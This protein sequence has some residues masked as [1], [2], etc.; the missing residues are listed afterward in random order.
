[1]TAEPTPEFEELAADLGQR[2][3][4]A[5][6]R[7]LVLRFGDETRIVGVA[8]RMPPAATLEAPLDELHSTLSGRRTAEELRSLRWI[9]NPEPY[10]AL[11]GGG[12]VVG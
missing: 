10:I 11:L 3:I 1:M 7:G 12:E 4:D 6:L 5:G 8:D 9:G 2:I